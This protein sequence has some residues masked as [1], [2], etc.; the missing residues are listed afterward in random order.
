MACSGSG[1]RFKY[2]Q[3][4]KVESIFSVIKKKYGSR[5]RARTFSSQKKEVLCKLVAY[6]VDKLSTFC[7]LVFRGFQQSPFLMYK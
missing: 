7:Y 2:H 5:L 3:R 1:E 6:N 4:N